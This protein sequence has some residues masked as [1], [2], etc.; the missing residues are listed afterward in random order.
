[1]PDKLMVMWQLQKEF[2]K[3]FY[4]PDN[5]T[6]EEKIK[7]S[8]EFILSM[9]RELGEVLNEM[10]WKLHRAGDK[11]TFSPEHIQEELIDCLKVL[12]N[13]CIV[14][15]LDESTLFDKFVEKTKIVQSRFD[16]EK[17]KLS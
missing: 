17:N 12:M 5:I 6:P 1:M 2:Q 16:E 11:Q 14:W 9:H 15:G 10:P 7:L 8:K 3:N 13:V 4:D